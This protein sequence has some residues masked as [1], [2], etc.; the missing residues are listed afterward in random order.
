MGRLK[1]LFFFQAEDGIRAGTV[2]EF[3]RVLFRSED[4]ITTF[5]PG[6]RG[7]GQLQS[8]VR[9]LATLAQEYGARSEE[10]RV[11]KEC[12]SRWSPDALKIQDRLTME[13]EAAGRKQ[14]LMEH[15][16]VEAVPS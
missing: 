5:S 12:R 7:I 15:L 16:L 13:A 8:A 9:A 6:I 3:R 10:R 11:G 4:V 2:T 14:H 1:S